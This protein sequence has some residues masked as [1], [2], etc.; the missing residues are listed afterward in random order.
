MKQIKFNLR[1]MLETMVLCYY[2]DYV[3]NYGEPFTSQGKELRKK[4]QGYNSYWWEKRGFF[5]HLILDSAV[6]ELVKTPEGMQDYQKL[7]KK[8]REAWGGIIP[9]IGYCQILAWKK[10]SWKEL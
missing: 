10:D 5:Q 4:G 1:V 8:C 7:M 2:H 9:P 3:D 6:E